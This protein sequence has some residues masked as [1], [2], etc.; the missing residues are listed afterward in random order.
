MNTW[1]VEYIDKDGWL[2]NDNTL[3]LDGSYGDIVNSFKDEDVKI[4]PLN[5]FKSDDDFV[6]NHYFEDF[7]L[8]SVMDKTLMQIEKSFRQKINLIK[9]KITDESKKGNTFIE[10]IFDNQE[11]YN[12][13]TYYFQKLGFTIDI[14]N[15]NII[16]RW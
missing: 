11:E 1:K 7:S 12:K 6:K 10:F 5:T 9:K 8:K 3:I 13:I 16:F 15:E 14:K 2:K 4:S